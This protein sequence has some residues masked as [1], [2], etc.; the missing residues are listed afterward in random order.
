MFLDSHC[1]VNTAWLQP[2]LG[3]LQRDQHTVVCPVIDIISADTLVYSPSPIVRGGFNW[4]LHF[5]WDPVPPA[6]LNGPDGAAGAFRSVGS[7]SRSHDQG[8][9]C[10][11]RMLGVWSFYREGKIDRPGNGFNML[12]CMFPPSAVLHATV[13]RKRGKQSALE[14]D[15]AQRSI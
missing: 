11:A 4:G 2:L 10:T 12:P 9:T 1:E 5:K 8:L 6:E 14:S 15:K 3:L 13:I 7:G